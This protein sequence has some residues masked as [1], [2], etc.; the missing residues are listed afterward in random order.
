MAVGLA[1]SKCPAARSSFVSRGHPRG[2]HPGPP[3]ALAVPRVRGHHPRLALGTVA[4]QGV[5]LG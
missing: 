4:R 2:A 3:G 1:A 5:H